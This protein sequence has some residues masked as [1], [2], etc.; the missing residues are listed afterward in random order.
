MIKALLFR[1]FWLIR[2]RLMTT[3]SFMVMLPLLL[4]IGITMVMKNI[5]VQ[6]ID[7]VP[8]DVWVFPGIILLIA[9]VS[10]FSLIYRDLFDLRIHKKSFIPIT[11]APYGKTHL[12]IGFLVT[13]IIESLVYVIVAMGV[14]TVLLPE[15]LNWSAYFIVPLFTLLYTFLLGNL[16][17]TFSVLTDRISTY[18]SITISM[19]LFIL[20]ATGVLVEFDFYPKTIG[21]LLSYFP[22]S[23]ILSDLRGILFFN[24]V[25]WGP[26]MIPVA[27]A[28]GWTWLN[29]YMLKRKLKQ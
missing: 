28:L 12:V 29:G 6:S 7:Q 15:P 13:S 1:R 26:I 18:L 14:L 23:M 17:I 4:H 27:T 11:L 21:T 19:F 9:S 5:V 2:H 3:V 20:F 10:T 25:E 8:Y 16:I 24:R 22:L